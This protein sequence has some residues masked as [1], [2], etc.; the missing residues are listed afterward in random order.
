MS[1]DLDR[2]DAAIV[3]VEGQIDACP[4]PEERKL[5]RKKEEQLREERLILLRK[6]EGNVTNMCNSFHPAKL[7]LVLS[8][9]FFATEPFCP[10]SSTAAAPAPDSSGDVVSCAVLAILL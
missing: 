9:G 6:T 7:F 10:R 3:K 8:L 5:L 4:D 1:S 2:I